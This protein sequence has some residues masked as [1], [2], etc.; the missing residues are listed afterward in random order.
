M[1]F[2]DCVEDAV[3]AGRISR[4]QAADL[5]QRQRDATDRFTLDPQHSAESAARMAEELGLER[6]KQDVRFAKVP[7]GTA[8]DPQQRQ[9]HTHPRLSARPYFRGAHTAGAG[10]PRQGHACQCG[11]PRARHFGPGS[12][13][14]GRGVV[15][16][17]HSLAW[18]A[19]GQGTAQGCHSRNVS[20]CR[21]RQCGR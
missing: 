15:E 1:S 12:R 20:R 16:A 19:S 7:G 14:H 6:A 2:A 5:Y 8:G 4:D 3:K 18:P 11:N 9:H 13:H 10:R 21:Y 17:A